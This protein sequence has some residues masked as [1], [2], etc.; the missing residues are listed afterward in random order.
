[1]CV[2]HASSIK[3]LDVKNSKSHW[4]QP[5]GSSIVWAFSCFINQTT[6]RS[7]LDVTL[8]SAKGFIDSVFFFMLHKLKHLMLNVTRGVAEW[9][10]IWADYLIVIQ[11]TQ[12][13]AFEAT[14]GV[15]KWFFTQVNNLMLLQSTWYLIWCH[16]RNSYISL[17]MVAKNCSYCFCA[18]THTHSKASLLWVRGNFGYLQAMYWNLQVK[19]TSILDDWERGADVVGQQSLHVRHPVR[20]AH[21]REKRWEPPY[22]QWPSYKDCKQI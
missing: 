11:S 12:C 22:S 8:G 18:M 2:F 1:M 14:L 19:K 6:C 4:E 10:I 20:L 13:W 21:V 15:A 7:R 9:F 17:L 16:A 5:K 3:A